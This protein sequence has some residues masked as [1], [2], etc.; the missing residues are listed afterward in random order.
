LEKRTGKEHWAVDMLSDFN[1]MMDQ[2]GYSESLLVHDSLVFCFPGGKE[3]NI[4]ALNRFN[5]STVWASEALRDTVTYCSPMLIELP[6]RNVLVTFSGHYLMGLDASNGK[7]LWWHEQVYHIYHQHC[8]TPVYKNGY[9]Y[10]LSGEGNGVVK[11]KLDDDGGSITEVWRNNHVDNVFHGFILLDNYLFATDK[12]Q[13]LK[14]L[15]MQTGQVVDSLRVN[16]GALIYADGMFVCYSESGD[17]NLI[18]HNG[19]AM[20][21]VGKFKCPLG[22]REHFAHPVISKGVL[23]LRHGNALMAYRVGE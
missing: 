22:T 13:K 14:C 2:H 12:A 11:L 9:I 3:K 1:G 4:V 15:D 17:V 10:Y 7:L 21:N 16:R 5:G 6:A 20:E 18:R 23:Y 8:N 19:T